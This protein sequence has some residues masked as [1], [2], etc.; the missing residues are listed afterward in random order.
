[1]GRVW[2]STVSPDLASKDGSLMLSPTVP[3]RRPLSMKEWE[4]SQSYYGLNIQ[5]INGAHLPISEKFKENPP[6]FP[7]FPPNE[8]VRIMVNSPNI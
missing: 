1:L 4:F 3:G 5:A 7:L 2:Q 6:F 8:Y